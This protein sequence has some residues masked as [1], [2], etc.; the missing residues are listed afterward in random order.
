MFASV[1]LSEDS[2][3]VLGISSKEGEPVRYYGTSIYR[4]HIT[5]RDST[6]I[7][8]VWQQHNTQHTTY[9]QTFHFALHV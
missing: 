9:N 7:I 8:W 3:Q 4:P 1:I 6:Y 2:T 5:S